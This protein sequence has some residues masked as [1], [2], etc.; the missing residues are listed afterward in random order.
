[1]SEVPAEYRTAL[2]TVADR[3]P[4]LLEHPDEVVAWQHMAGA[5]HAWWYALADEQRRLLGGFQMEFPLEGAATFTLLYRPGQDSQ[6]CANDLHA[7]RQIALA[8]SESE[9]EK[10]ATD[11]S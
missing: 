5:M 11:A 6:R 7:R 3:T 2:Q 1:M 9:V 10:G 4:W 8:A